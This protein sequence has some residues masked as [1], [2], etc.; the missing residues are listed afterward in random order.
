MSTKTPA[1]IGFYRFSHTKWRSRLQR[2]GENFK[3]L[4]QEHK[5]YWSVFPRGWQNYVLV[6]W[7]KPKAERVCRHRKSGIPGIPT[8]STTRFQT[9]SRVP[10]TKIYHQVLSYGKPFQLWFDRRL[11]V[12]PEGVRSLTISKRRELVSIFG[13]KNDLRAF[14]DRER[15][16]GKNRKPPTVP[17]VLIAIRW[18]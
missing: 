14:W 13:V 4:S 5:W 3:R 18:G 2:I 15:K 10:S 6:C 1:K 11:Q 12:L 9:V 8:R 16:H 7:D 17:R